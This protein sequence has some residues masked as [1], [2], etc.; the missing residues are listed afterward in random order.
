MTTFTQVDPGTFLQPEKHLPPNGRGAWTKTGIGFSDRYCLSKDPAERIGTLANKS[1]A[2]WAVAAGA[3]AIQSRLVKLGLMD[4]VAENE[5]GVFGL[6]TDKAVR[7]FQSGSVDPESGAHL[8]V[9]GIVGRSDA[10][11]LFTPLIDAA[12]R[13]LG[14]PDRLLR[15][16]CNHESALDPGAVGYWIYYGATLEY[17]GV[18]RGALQINSRSNPQVSWEKAFD[19]GYATSWS[20][21]SLAAHHDEYA[22]RF[23]EQTPTVLWEAAALAHNNPSAGLQ[24]ARTGVLPSEAAANYLKAV[25]TARY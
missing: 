14:I 7:T 13:K 22:T 15:G 2:H 6:R 1:L 23:P 18:D 3:Y 4:T 12:E 10:R 17:R 20:A 11:A 21:A 9:D 19:F 16:Q 24:Y 25:L 8:V 5:R